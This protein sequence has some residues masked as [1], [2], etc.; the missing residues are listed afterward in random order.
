M[1]PHSIR[2]QRHRLASSLLFISMVGSYFGLF[3]SLWMAKLCPCVK[4]ITQL[5]RDKNRPC[6]PPDLF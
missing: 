5:F 3:Q 2:T 6:M 1:M 4:A